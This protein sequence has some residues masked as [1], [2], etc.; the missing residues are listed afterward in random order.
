MS[1]VKEKIT[2]INDTIYN[3]VLISTLIFVIIVACILSFAYYKRQRIIKIACL[4]SLIQP[5]LGLPLKLS[6]LC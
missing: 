6:G 3:I 2:Y 4:A 5:E 1:S